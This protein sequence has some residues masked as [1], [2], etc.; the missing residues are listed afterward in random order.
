MAHYRKGV[1]MATRIVQGIG[2]CA[3]MLSV[4]ACRSETPPAAESSAAP[5]AD[6]SHSGHVGGK[7]FFVS[8]KN[9]DTIKASHRFEFGSDMFTIAAVPEGEVKPEAVRAGLGHYHL[10]LDTDCLPAGQA[11][12]KGDPTWI[13]FG[14]GN[15]NIEMQLKPGPH[16]FSVQA[17]DDLHQAV[18]G[19]CETISVT[20]Q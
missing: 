1:A 5:A 7:V 10:G 17:G 4:A 15:N 8:P 14:T 18:A 3:L 13:H 19:L 16:K 6:A 2:I 11:I 9:G 12:P 20:V